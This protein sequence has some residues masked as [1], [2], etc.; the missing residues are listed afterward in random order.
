MEL[1]R[2]EPDK[3]HICL[4]LG[5]VFCIDILVLK[6]QRVNPAVFESC[7][8]HIRKLYISDTAIHLR[9]RVVRALYRYINSV[10]YRWRCID[11]AIQRDTSKLMY[12][13]PSVS[14]AIHLSK[15][16]IIFVMYRRDTSRYIYP[17]VWSERCIDTSIP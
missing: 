6:L 12:H 4:C 8:F 15:R 10:M 13:H 3:K 14:A 17:R 9:T 5:V 16:Y 7:L 1:I 11:T 2:C